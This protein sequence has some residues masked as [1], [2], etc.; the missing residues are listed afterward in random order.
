MTKAQ[1]DAIASPADGLI[2]YCSDCSPKGFRYRINGA[3]LNTPSERV[4]LTS[5]N[6]GNSIYD[7]NGDCTDDETKIYM[8]SVTLTPGKWRVTAQGSGY[9]YSGIA[10]SVNLN[11]A[12]VGA[13]YNINGAAGFYFGLNYFAE[14]SI[15]AT[16]TYTP[17]LKP[18]NGCHQSSLDKVFNHAPFIRYLNPFGLQSEQ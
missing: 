17:Y 4:I 15:G 1:R 9:K 7:G 12:P 10:T 2:I 3:W 11:G 14:V 16:T 5:N 18:V 8:S 6:P 13:I